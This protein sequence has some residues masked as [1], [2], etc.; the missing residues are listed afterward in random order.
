MEEE[1]TEV[2]TIQRRR[3]K[4]P[5]FWANAFTLIFLFAMIMAVQNYSKRWFEKGPAVE[6]AEKQIVLEDLENQKPMVEAEEVKVPKIEEKTKTENREPKTEN[7]KLK[8]ESRKPKAEKKKQKMVQVSPYAK[9]DPYTNG[10]EFDLD[11]KENQPKSEAKALPPLSKQ[12]DR[13][14][15]FESQ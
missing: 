13:F 12:R 11:R 5:S 9:P 2:T 14:I 1:V 8:T 7:R 10:S 6:D 15:P 3:R 4:A